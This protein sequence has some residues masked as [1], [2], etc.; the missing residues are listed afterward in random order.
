MHNT[1]IKTLKLINSNLTIVC[2]HYTP[3]LYAKNTI[4]RLNNTLKYKLSA[5]IMHYAPKQNYALES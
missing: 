1:H 3:K 4:M 2:T 5:Y